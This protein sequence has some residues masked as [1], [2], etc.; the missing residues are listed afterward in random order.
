MKVAVLIETVL[1]LIE[2]N[3]FFICAIIKNILLIA[4]QIRFFIKTFLVL[5]SL[6]SI[7]KK[8]CTHF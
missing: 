2:L 1:T 6:T 7:L 8:M 5:R 4:I 3:T